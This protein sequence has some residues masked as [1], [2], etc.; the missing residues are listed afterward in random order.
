MMNPTDPG[1]RHFNCTE[2]A[3]LPISPRKIIGARNEATNYLRMDSNLAGRIVLVTGASGG[4][5]SAIA[6]AFAAEGARVALHYR[7]DR[8]SAE[9]LAGELG[10]NSPIFRADLTK[11]RD[12]CRLF[13]AVIRRFS[14]VDALIANAGTWVARDIP[15]HKMSLKQWRYTV[16]QVLVSTFLSLREF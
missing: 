6:R 12:T 7:K 8:A 3:Y 15:M 4:V 2:S 14:R 16:D 13:E 10:T 1:Y 11:E 5:G 9:R